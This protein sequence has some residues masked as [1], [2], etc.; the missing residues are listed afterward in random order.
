MAEAEVKEEAEAEVMAEAEAE[1]KVEAEV[2]AELDAEVKVEAEVGV[3]ESQCHQ[4]LANIDD[5]GSES[6]NKLGNC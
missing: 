1:V 6:C 5:K 3:G 4:L 2:K